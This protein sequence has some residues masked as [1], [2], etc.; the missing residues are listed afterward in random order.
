MWKLDVFIVFK[1]KLRIHIPYMV[2]PLTFDLSGLE[3]CAHS[4][5]I[6]TTRVKLPFLYSLTSAKGDGLMSLK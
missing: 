4:S 6:D 1:V 2:L 3:P 5:K